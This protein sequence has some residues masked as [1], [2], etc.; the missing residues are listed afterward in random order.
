MCQAHGLALGQRLHRLWQL[1]GGR[2]PR[3]AYEHRDHALALLQS[4]FDFD[5]DK[6]I[7]VVQSP[8]ALLVARVEPTFSDH[9]D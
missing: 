8:R 4:R 9:R 1:I 5:A 7:G 3:L 6:V 2:Y